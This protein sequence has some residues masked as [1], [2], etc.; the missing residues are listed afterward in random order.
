[1]SRRPF[2]CGNWKMNTR[3]EEGVELAKEISKDSLP[4]SLDVVIA[5]PFTHIYPIREVLS[6][7][8]I[9]LSSQ[10][11]SDEDLGAHT[12]EIAAEMLI[13][14]GVKYAI[15]GHSEARARGQSDELI[16]KKIRKSLDKGL[17][18]IVCVGEEESIKEE[19]KTRE[20]VLKQVGK[21]MEGLSSIEMEKIIIAYEPIWAIGTGKTASAEDAQ[22]MAQVIRENIEQKYPGLDS[23]IRILYGGSAKASNAK[24]ILEKEDVDGL[25][26]GGASLKAEEFLRIVQ[27]GAENE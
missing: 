16:S 17:F 19:G 5:P 13:D 18:P 27:I 24:S 10:D 25:L 4:S 2:I 20:F 8:S 15:I 9:Q 22:E 3:I 11:I 6:D 21:L 1:M 23:K 12:G 14:L 26:I 7:S